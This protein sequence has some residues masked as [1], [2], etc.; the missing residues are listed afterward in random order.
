METDKKTLMENGDMCRCFLLM[1]HSSREIYKLH[2]QIQVR[3]DSELF[4]ARME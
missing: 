4:Q 1:L 3:Y 2:C